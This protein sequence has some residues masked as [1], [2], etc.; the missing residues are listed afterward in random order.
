MPTK[1]FNE[2]SSTPEFINFQ[3]KDGCQVHMIS[4]SKTYQPRQC[5]RASCG[6]PIKAPNI[7]MDA[8]QNSRRDD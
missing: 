5:N 3:T 6:W 2:C 7:S 8:A 1:M 4:G